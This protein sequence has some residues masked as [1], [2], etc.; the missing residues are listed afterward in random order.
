MEDFC[1]ILPEIHCQAIGEK[2]TAAEVER[3]YF[4]MY[5]ESYQARVTPAFV[6]L[7]H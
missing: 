6:C 1:D 2:K 7:N 4:Y 3:I 5:T